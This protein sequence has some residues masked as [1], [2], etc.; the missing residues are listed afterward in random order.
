MEQVEDVK[1]FYGILKVLL[2]LGFVCALNDIK[3]LYAFRNDKD[4]YNSSITYELIVIMIP[5]YVCLVRLFIHYY[6]PRLLKHIGLGNIVN[7]LYSLDLHR[8]LYMHYMVQ[9][10]AYLH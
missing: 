10:S 7:C 2:S 5:L 1:A 4:F 6:L 8:L 9:S 3:R